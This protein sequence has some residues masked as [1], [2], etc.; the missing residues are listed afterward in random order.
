VNNCA[1]YERK[2]NVTKR[3]VKITI[4]KG[5]RWLMRKIKKTPENIKQRLWEREKN[6]NKKKRN[7]KRNKEEKIKIRK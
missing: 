5:E 2:K 1:R 3:R 4:I 7:D 6:G